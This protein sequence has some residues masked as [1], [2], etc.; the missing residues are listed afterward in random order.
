VATSGGFWVAIGDQLLTIPSISPSVCPK[1]SLLRQ[2]RKITVDGYR[3]SHMAIRFLRREDGSGR[4]RKT[5]ETRPIAGFADRG[6]ARRINGRRLRRKFA[7]R[8]NGQGAQDVGGD[9]R[10]WI[11]SVASRP[12]D[13]APAV[14]RDGR[15]K[16]SPRPW[17]RR[18]SRVEKGFRPPAPSTQL[19][20]LHIVELSIE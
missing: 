9:L 10:P 12:I 5:A 1:R 19:T 13:V 16:T 15:L 4:P 14:K 2:P 11:G 3:Q 20:F 6:A 8:G 17:Q 7:A 18:P